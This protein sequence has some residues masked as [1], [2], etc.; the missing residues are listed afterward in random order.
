MAILEAQMSGNSAFELVNERGWKRG[1]SNLMNNEFASWWKTSMWWTQVLIW[2]G[3]IGFMLGA[4]VLG[5]GEGLSTGVVL[6]SIFGGLFPSVAVIIIMQEAV[7]GEKQSGTA[8]WV[9]SKPV[10]RPAFILSKLAADSFGVLVTIVLIPGLAAYTILSISNG[11]PLNPVN[12]LGGM[13]VLWLVQMF[14]L[15][16]TLMLGTFYNTRGP[17]IGFALALLFVQQY[18]VGMLP[19]ARLFLP[20]TL[21]AP[22]NGSDNS[23]VS[24]LLLGNAPDSILQIL[25]VAVEIVLFVWIAIRRFEKE[26][27]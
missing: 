23:L 12:F 10:S 13:L 18:I 22:P 21:I 27:F 26:E 14:F 25:V 19:P 3:I 24:G 15:T 16:F 9:L 2:T 5:S 11:K 8:A 4:V 17:V 6:Y 20:W 7:V 1:L